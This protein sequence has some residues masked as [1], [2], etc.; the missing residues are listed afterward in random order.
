MQQ[1]RTNKPTG[2]T[3]EDTNGGMHDTLCN[4]T[5]MLAKLIQRPGGLL[6]AW[7]NDRIGSQICLSHD[8]SPFDMYVCTH[9]EARCQ[10][11]NL[12]MQKNFCLCRAKAE[13]NHQ[14]YKFGNRVEVSQKVSSL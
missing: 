14:K 13:D 7:G 6:L 11:E 12:L 9:K 2:E 3:E 1:K 8:E 10:A 5:A 4:H